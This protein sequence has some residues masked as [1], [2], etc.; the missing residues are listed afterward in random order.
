MRSRSVLQIGKYNWVELQIPPS[1][2]ELFDYTRKGYRSNTC[3]YKLSAEI[4]NQLVQMIEE[5]KVQDREP[6]LFN[7]FWDLPLV[8]MLQRQKMTEVFRSITKAIGRIGN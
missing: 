6:Q 7:V 1:Y 5:E 3:F 8:L 4:L 2:H